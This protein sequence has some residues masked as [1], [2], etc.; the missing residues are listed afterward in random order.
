MTAATYSTDLSTLSEN[1]ASTNMV[2]P[3]ATT[4]ENWTNLNAVT[5]AENDFYIQ[6]TTCTSAT[7][8]AG[9]GGLIYNNG[10]GFTIPTDGAV[11]VW[12]YFWAPANLTTTAS[13]GIR[14]MI[15]SG[16]AAFFWT[17]HGGS[18]TWTYGGWLCLAMGDPSAI[19]VNTVGSPTATRQYAGWGYN[20]T[21][22]PA[23]GNPYG[24]DAIRYGRCSI[25]VISGGTI[26]GGSG[27]YGTFVDIAFFNDR[28][29]TTANSTHTLLNSGYHRFGIFQF[30]DGAYKM[31]GRLALGS[32]GTAVDFRDSNRAITILNTPAVTRNFNTIEVLNASSRVDWTGISISKVGNWSKGRFVATNNADINFDAC[33]FTDMDTFTFASNSTILNSV[34]RRCNIV[35]QAGATFTSCT[36]DSSYGA[37]ALLATD[38]SVVT[39]CSFVSSGIGYAIEGFSTAGDYSVSTNTFTGYASTWGGTGDRHWSYVVSGLHFNGTNASTTFTDAKG[40]TWTANGNA[41]LSTSNLKFGT[42]NAL[43]DG[44]GDFITT[45]W[46]SD[47]DPGTGDYTVDCWVF[48]AS[49]DTANQK[50][51]LTTRPASGQ[52]AGLIFGIIFS[53]SAW[54]P[55]LVGWNT[56]G[57]A[58]LALTS[59]GSI[60]SSTWTHVAW[61]RS[62]GTWTIYI[63]GTAAGSA[64]E[65]SDVAA[66]N[67]LVHIGRDPF[68]TARDWNGRLDDLRVSK[69]IARWTA[70]F[71]APTAEWDETGGKVGSEALHVL[72]TTGTVNINAPAGTSYY[73]EGATVNIIAGAVTT[74]VTVTDVSGT[75]IQNARVFLRA[76]NNTGPL[77]YDVTVTI[78]NSGTTATVTH[79]SHG[80]S[81]NDKVVISGASLNAN[82]GVFS[83][84]V[85][86]VNT[87]TYTMASSP[88]SSPTGTIKST[89]VALEGTTNASGQIS[90]TRVFSAD[91]PV[92]GWARKSSSAP[93]YKTGPIVGTIDSATGGT[94]S[95]VLIAD[96]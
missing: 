27:A 33:T 6:N 22:A 20:A 11:L 7:I 8:K 44:T 26:G 23:R 54:R 16:T 32:A 21:S 4:P 81:T 74:Q 46:S 77:P 2:E 14:T 15:G 40:K 55:L 24:I 84:T 45:P 69:G 1:T 58:S 83:I 63:D 61:V 9:I 49:T 73:S 50:T 96:Q 43:F 17:T 41:Q 62:N 89:Y 82:N 64:S 70:N 53:T 72:A 29:D 18:D 79:T 78:S 94:F 80:M 39:D 51:I 52:A 92:I 88:G 34:F 60:T 57:V 5:S 86:G 67:S 95:A 65:T 66:G 90:M 85:T 38:V 37:E 28:N 13:G 47:F 71:T 68:N 93:Y 35:T 12:A 91:Q 87:Y 3:T 56:M 19:A 10:A 31:Q 75:A 42:A 48:N 36:F 25:Q 30:Q 59:T 76:S